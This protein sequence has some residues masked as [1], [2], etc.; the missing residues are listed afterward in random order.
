VLRQKGSL[1]AAQQAY[2]ESLAISREIGDRSAVAL[3]LGNS[4][5]LYRVRGDVGQA[6][7]NYLES[8]AIRREIGEKAAIAATLNN[9]ANLMSDEG[10]LNGAMKVYEETLVTLEELGDK[11]GIAIAWYNMGEMERLQA[12]LPRARTLLDQSLELRKSLEDK[13]GVARSLASIGLVQ[14]AQGRLPEAKKTYEEA[15]ALQ[16][17]VGDKVGIARVLYFQ[18]ML[19]FHEG[20]PSDAQALLRKAAEQFRE[21][22]ASD[23]EA[24]ALGILAR[25]LLAEQKTR[26]AE[27]ASMEALRLMHDSRNRVSIFEAGL[28]AARVQAA[29]GKRSAATARLNTLLADAKGYRGLELETL[30]ALGEIEIAS[31]QIA[32]G[33]SRLDSVEHQARAKGLLLIANQAA[34]RR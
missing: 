27:H 17:A 26:E 14:E 29:T 28:A 20:R 19:A 33:R 4:A 1:E 6:K 32:Q 34:A 8:L 10:D 31:G 9:L 13:G 21:L 12:N 24:A 15:L 18:G 5:I 23:D 3:V 2:G 16:T 11:R 30:L 7:K 22:K 25:A